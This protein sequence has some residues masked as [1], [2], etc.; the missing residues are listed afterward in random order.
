MVTFPEY[1]PTP[2]PATEAFTLSVCGAVPLVGETLS[3]LESLLAVKE[4]EPDPV[5]V[6]ESDAGVGSGPPCVA[7]NDRLGGET[8]RIGWT[9]VVPDAYADAGPS[10]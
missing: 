4:S 7:A 10:A 3:Q 5:F 9:A 8:E 6:T 2:R 1:D